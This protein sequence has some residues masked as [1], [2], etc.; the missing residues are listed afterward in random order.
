MC[1]YAFTYNHKIIF[2]NYCKKDTKDVFTYVA[3]Q[4][5]SIP[6]VLH[7]SFRGQSHKVHIQVGPVPSMPKG[8]AILLDRWVRLSGSG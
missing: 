3:I 4:S 7:K 5:M 6:R 8:S 1:T 2:L